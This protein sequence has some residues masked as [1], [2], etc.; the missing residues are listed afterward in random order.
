MWI[1]KYNN[2]KYL[3]NYVIYKTED[4]FYSKNMQKIGA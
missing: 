2:M 1:Y 4:F 3:N